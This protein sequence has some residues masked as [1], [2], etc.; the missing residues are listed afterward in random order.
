MYRFVFFIL[1]LASAMWAAA[2]ETP[3]SR[4]D[5]AIRKVLA[6]RIDLQKQATGIVIGVIDAKGSHTISYGTMGLSDKR[7]VNGDTVFDVG[8]ITKVFTALLLADMAQHGEVSVDDP[9]AKY[10]DAKKVKMPERAGKEITLADL[11]T[12]TSGLPLRPTNLVSK[13]PNDNTEATL[14]S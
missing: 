11:A 8:S 10:L 14:W 7:P 4:D 12:H 2:S 3:R 9:A 5:E 13:D 6:T 1:L